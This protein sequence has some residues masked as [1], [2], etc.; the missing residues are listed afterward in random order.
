MSS[1]FPTQPSGERPP[2]GTPPI[3]GTGFAGGDSNDP[4]Y[5]LM[6]E[7]YEVALR[8]EAEELQALKAPSP[9]DI[10][11]ATD[12]IASLV[13]SSR[14]T[15]HDLEQIEEF[16]KTRHKAVS[17]QI[18]LERMVQRP[19]K[20]GWVTGSGAN[21]MIPLYEK[22]LKVIARW[23]ERVAAIIQEKVDS[24]TEDSSPND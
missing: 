24:A 16:L 10:G 8:R 2:G 20:E 7:I 12:S 1:D 22:Q 11:D 5:R 15:L 4:T 23:L 19:D 14:V 21:G 6:R 9:H 18:E 17:D 3:V 13:Y